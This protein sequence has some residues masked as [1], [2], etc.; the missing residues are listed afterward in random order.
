M[1]PRVR[2]DGEGMAPQP[3]RFIAERGLTSMTLRHMMS[4]S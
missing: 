1:T 4:E 3:R 2:S